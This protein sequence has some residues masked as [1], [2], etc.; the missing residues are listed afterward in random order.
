MIHD[1]V[2]LRTQDAPGTFVPEAETNSK[3]HWPTAFRRVSGTSDL[4]LK[5]QYPLSIIGMRDQNHDG[6]NAPNIDPSRLRRSVLQ[7]NSIRLL[8]MRLPAENDDLLNRSGANRA[9][10]AGPRELAP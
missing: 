6:P 3:S 5:T 7:V 4:D 8:P 2:G 10:V 9:S 1:Y